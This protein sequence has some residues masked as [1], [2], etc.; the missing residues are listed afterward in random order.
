[1]LSTDSDI[2]SVSVL[3]PSSPLLEIASNG[4]GTPVTTC[5]DPEDR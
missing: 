3:C 2:R 1:M 4:S 5:L